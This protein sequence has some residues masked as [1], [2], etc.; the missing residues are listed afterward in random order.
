MPHPY[1][2]DKTADHDLADLSIL[3][4]IPRLL[5]RHHT[6]ERLPVQVEKFKLPCSMKFRFEYT[7]IKMIHYI[8]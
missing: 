6:S 8:V 3:Q 1:D 4:A 5:E 7:P 2:H